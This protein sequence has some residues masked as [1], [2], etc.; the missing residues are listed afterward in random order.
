MAGDRSQYRK[1]QLAVQS[2]MDDIEE[3]LAALRQH[4]H[5]KGLVNF[6]SLQFDERVARHRWLPS[7][8][9]VANTVRLAVSLGLLDTD[10]TP[11]R[12][13]RRSTRSDAEFARALRDLALERL[14]AADASKQDLNQAASSLLNERPPRMPTSRSL[15]DAIEPSLSRAKFSQ[16]LTLLG[17]CGFAET[18]QRKLYLRFG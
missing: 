8:R 12:A 10:G 13:G 3:G 14:D 5:G 2:A 1:L 4:I 6:E 7:E 9:V 11:T 18:S 16:L 15:W 17:D